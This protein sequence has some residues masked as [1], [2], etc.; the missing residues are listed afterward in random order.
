MVDGGG[1]RAQGL[2][3]VRVVVP[4]S[5]NATATVTATV[6]FVNGHVHNASTA[7][8]FAA[9]TV[10]PFQTVAFRDVPSIRAVILSPSTG[11]LSVSA[12]SEWAAF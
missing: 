4:A 11:T 2:Y 10:T 7:S 12:G 5:A 1:S 8:V 6:G 9:L 3:D